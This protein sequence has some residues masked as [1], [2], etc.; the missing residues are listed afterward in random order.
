MVA[1][2]TPW[3]CRRDH[4]FYGN[5]RLVR[6]AWDFIREFLVT[7]LVAAARERLRDRAR[8]KRLLARAAAAVVRRKVVRGAA[9]VVHVT[10]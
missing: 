4:L 1:E 7:R 5:I 2:F 3:L 6:L 9:A 10:D 8:T